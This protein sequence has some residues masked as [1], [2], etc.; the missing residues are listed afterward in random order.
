MGRLFFKDNEN[1]RANLTL[2]I[3]YCCD[4]D[5]NSYEFGKLNAVAPLVNY[6]T[7]KNKDVLKGVCIAVYHLSKEP[8]NCV[9]M[10]TC[11]VIKV[12]LVA[13]VSCIRDIN[14]IARY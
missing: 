10:H 5:R 8:L 14:N 7:S 9:T 1:L 2:A 3:A 11:G 6:M 13:Y 12:Q 4:W